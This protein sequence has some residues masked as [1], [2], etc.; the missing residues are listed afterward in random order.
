MGQVGRTS[1]QQVLLQRKWRHPQLQG[2]ELR[3]VAEAAVGKP[4]QRTFEEDPA[5]APAA[6]VALEETRSVAV[7]AI[8]TSTTMWVTHS[9]T[10]SSSPNT[11]REEEEASIA[12]PRRSNTALKTPQTAILSRRAHRGEG[13]ITSSEE[14]SQAKAPVADIVSEEIRI[15]EAGWA[16]SSFL[17]RKDTIRGAAIVE[18]EEAVVG[19]TTVEVATIREVQILNAAIEPHRT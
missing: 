10:S 2:T 7:E 3:E 6:S 9:T 12:T 14:V 13:R 16:T 18:E 8:S 15:R 5:T 17:P 19:A 1:T 4:S 11:T